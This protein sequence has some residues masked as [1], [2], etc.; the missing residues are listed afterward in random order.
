MCGKG[1]YIRRRFLTYM[2]R[3]EEEEEKLGF[4]CILVS[5]EDF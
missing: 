1:F 2:V 3:Y 5:R 4:V